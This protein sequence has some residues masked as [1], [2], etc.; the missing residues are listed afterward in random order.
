MVSVVLL[1]T[2]GLIMLI[3]PVESVYPFLFKAP[4]VYCS[5]HFLRGPTVLLLTYTKR[6]GPGRAESVVPVRP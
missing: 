5:H 2:F 3:V 4:V 6:D 1:G